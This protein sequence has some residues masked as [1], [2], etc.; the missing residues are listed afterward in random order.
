MSH[1]YHGFPSLVCRET[2]D[3]RALAAVWRHP[4]DRGHPRTPL[5]R[6][7]SLQPLQLICIIAPRRMAANNA[8]GAPQLLEA[9]MRYDAWTG[10]MTVVIALTATAACAAEMPLE[11]SGRETVQAICVRCH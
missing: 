9:I 8:Y 6:V 11:R 5:S 3:S 7:V 10:A 4:C 2:T 1:V